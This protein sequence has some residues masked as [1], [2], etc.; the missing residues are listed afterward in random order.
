M[1]TDLRVPTPQ[2][3]PIQATRP[4]PYQPGGVGPFGA[5]E[6]HEEYEGYRSGDGAYAR[7]GVIR[8]WPVTSGAFTPFTVAAQVPTMSWAPRRESVIPWALKRL[9]Q[10]GVFSPFMEEA[11]ESTRPTSWWMN[12]P[13]IQ[14]HRK[15]LLQVGHFMPLAISLSPSLWMHRAPDPTL[16]RR[17]VPP[18]VYVAPPLI[19]TTAPNAAMWYGWEPSSLDRRPMPAA[20][21]QALAWF[22]LVPLPPVVDLDEFVQQA[23]RPDRAWA[24]RLLDR[25]PHSP[26]LFWSTQFAGEPL[27]SMWRPT[28]PAR[29]P[30]HL[31]RPRGGPFEPPLEIGEAQV[32]PSMWWP[33]YPDLL[34]AAAV[35][36]QGENLTP[37]TDFAPV[38][39]WGPVY[40]DWFPPTVRSAGLY[41]RARPDTPFSVRLT[42]A[43]WQARYPD[44][45]HGLPPSPYG[46]AAAPPPLTTSPPL[47]S[48]WLGYEPER[49]YRPSILAALQ[50][51]YWPANF[52]PQPP[53]PSLSGW[54][55]PLSEPIA[56]WAAARLD[57]QWQDRGLWWQPRT[58]EDPPVSRFLP[59]YPPFLRGPRPVTF[60]GLTAPPPFTLTPPHVSQWLG[61]YPDWIARRL[62]PAAL[63]L[64]WWWF[65]ETPAKP[66]PDLAGF[67]RPF[68]GPVRA[69]QPS[70][71][72]ALAAFLMFGGVPSARPGRGFIFVDDEVAFVVTAMGE[73]AIVVT[74]TGE[75]WTLGSG[76]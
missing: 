60:S 11:L 35:R 75:T 26:A 74:A 14:P 50:R 7:I 30:S 55:R 13:Y 64:P 1:A 27:P 53:A 20:Q 68:V 66:A 19:T 16:P 44:M 36:M 45:V 59:T 54:W 41:L 8:R 21:Q 56:R 42:N 3:G 62:M 47:M 73:L 65:A 10:V 43:N 58:P 24:L 48:Q 39:A 57:R 15:R 25:A 12:L 23:A 38:L 2:A 40:P 70:H 49:V 18:S 71:H 69:Y 4:W 29:V 33:S 61:E 5:A 31:P 34:H 37:I 6:D 22:G 52:T 51:A 46:G 63:Q 9:L 32:I 76:G 67:F 17:R 28:F 72:A